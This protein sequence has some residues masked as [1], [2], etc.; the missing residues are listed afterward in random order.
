MLN[1]RGAGDSMGNWLGHGLPRPPWRL[2]SAI[3]IGR[4]GVLTHAKIPPILPDP[5]LNRPAVTSAEKSARIIRL[6]HSKCP[7]T[8]G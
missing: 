8:R 5:G 1:T 4:D 7:L 3:L 6:P 2:I